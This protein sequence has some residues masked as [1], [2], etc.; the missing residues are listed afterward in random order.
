MNI[1]LKRVASAPPFSFICCFMEKQRHRLVRF[2]LKNVF[3]FQVD[4]T[5]E[6]EAR[7]C[8]MTF[9]PHTSMWDFVIGKLVMIAMDLNSKTMIKKELFFFPLKY[10]LQSLGGVPVD[11]KHALRLPQQMAELLGRSEEMALLISPEGTRKLV[12]QWKRGFYYIACEA[13]VPIYLS[14]IDWG[15]RRAG[16]GPKL[17][18]T[19]DYA[20]DMVFIESFYRGMKGR[21]VG[22]FNLES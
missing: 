11:R 14:Y 3:R 1:T 10:L 16:I 20:A 19:G 8:V 7:K 2:L 15:T 12:R 17:I 18:P 4:Y 6:P 21:H 5:V 13:N 22:L 9:A